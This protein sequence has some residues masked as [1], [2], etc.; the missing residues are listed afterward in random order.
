MPHPKLAA[1]DMRLSTASTL[2]LGFVLI[3][4]LARTSQSADRPAE[5]ESPSPKVE[6]K[7]D[8]RL[9]MTPAIACRSIDGYENYEALPTASLTSDEKLLIY[10]RPLNYRVEQ[11][12]GNYHGH[13]T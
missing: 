3:V 9:T 12:D 7:A 8:D 13:M 10:Y 6:E 1:G 11:L 4:A 5:D 2:C